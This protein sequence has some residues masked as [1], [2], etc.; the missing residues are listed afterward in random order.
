MPDD[1]AL[2]S[3]YLTTYT[4]RETVYDYYYDYYW[5]TWDY[6]YSY[7]TRYHYYEGSAGRMVIDLIDGYGV[8]EILDDGGVLALTPLFTFIFIS[9]GILFTFLKKMPAVRAMGIASTAPLG[10]FAF[11]QLII[12]GD[13]LGAHAGFWLL[14]GGSIALIACSGQRYAKDETV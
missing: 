3:L 8:D 4:T 2:R 10:A 12:S 9:L 1:L 7:E 5:D 6:D 14:L 13:L 11:I